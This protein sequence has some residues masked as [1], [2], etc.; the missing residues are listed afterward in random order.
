MKSRKLLALLVGICLVLVLVA[1]PFMAACAKPAPPV[2][3]IVLGIP[4]SR[5]FAEGEETMEH[6][7]ILAIEE[8]NAAGGVDVAG[9]MRPFTYEIMDTRDLEAGVPVSE[10]LL[11]VERL[12]LDKKADFIVGGPIR[13][14]AYHAAMDLF[15]KYK[16]VSI[17]NTGVYSPATGARVAED[18]E[19]YKY[20][21]RNTGHVGTEIMM[22]LPTLLKPLQEDYGFTKAFIMV[23]DVAHARK[24]GDIVEAQLP[25]WGWEVLGKEIFPTGT[26]DYSLGLLKAKKAGAQFLW[27]WQDH[28]EVAILMRQW[29]DLEVPAIPMGYA[30]PAQDPRFWELTDG[31]CAYSVLTVLNAS[32]VP[33]KVTPWAERFA[34]D[35][36]ERWGIELTGYSCAAPYMSVYVLKDA[37]ERAGTLDSD[38][39]VTALE[40]TDIMGGVYGRT[41]FDPKSHDIIRSLDPEEG[42]LGCW[43]QWQDGKRIAIFPPATA[44]GEFQMPPWIGR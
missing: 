23:Q 29:A 39:V 17:V 24:S 15:S 4:S 32:N 30:R 20:C 13:T 9:V 10:S 28:P 22:E 18:Y 3:S 40:A 27:V 2:E 1:M 26:T 35:F 7:T 43:F 36:E 34:K 16:I 21:F 5:P 33:T 8:I 37:I 11:V 19:K 31:K 14:E 44:V 12:I 42:A 25:K 41:R 6:A 38:A